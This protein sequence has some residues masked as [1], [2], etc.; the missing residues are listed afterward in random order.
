MSGHGMVG[1]SICGVEGTAW[2]LRGTGVFVVA[3]YKRR[4]APFADMIQR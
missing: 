4:P 1:I 3:I 2:E